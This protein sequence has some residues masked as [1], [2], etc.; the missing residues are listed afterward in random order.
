MPKKNISYDVGDILEVNT[1]AGVK[2]YK[3]VIKKVQTKSLWTSLSDSS[4]K[5]EVEVRGFEGCFVRRSDL[6]ALKKMSV[7]YSGKEKL[8]KTISW[9]YDGQIIRKVKD[10]PNGR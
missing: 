5:D 10:K 8:S 1:F 7:P 2:I 9:T 3:K 4:K 6:Y